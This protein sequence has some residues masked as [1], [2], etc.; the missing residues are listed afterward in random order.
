MMQGPQKL[1]ILVQQDDPGRRLAESQRVLALLESDKGN[2][3]Q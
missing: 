2:E 1:R 3:Y